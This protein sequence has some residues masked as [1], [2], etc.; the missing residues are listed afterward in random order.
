MD[1]LTKFGSLLTDYLSPTNLLLLKSLAMDPVIHSKSSFIFGIQTKAKKSHNFSTKKH[2]G[3]HKSFEKTPLGMAI[4]GYICYMF[5]FCIGWIRE[6]L[7]GLGPVRGSSANRYQERNRD[8]YAP[9][10]ASFESFY[11]RNV[12][13]R[14]RNVFHQPI[15]SCPGAKVGLFFVIVAER[16]V[17]SLQNLPRY[18]L[19]GHFGRS[20]IR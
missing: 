7:F 9:L 15:A 20:G 14:L 2:G 10:Y 18:F 5:L 12:Y 3:G 4:A 1:F 17:Y 16:F 8:G 6:F 11:T 19:T 13:R